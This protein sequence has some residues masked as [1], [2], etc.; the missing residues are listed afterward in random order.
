MLEAG[1]GAAK[2]HQWCRAQGGARG[3]LPDVTRVR[4]LQRAL[5][6]PV[7]WLCVDFI[8][9]TLK[10]GL[11]MCGDVAGELGRRALT[12]DSCEMACADGVSRHTAT[13]AKRS[14]SLLAVI[15]KRGGAARVRGAAGVRTTKCFLLSFF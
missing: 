12:A 13:A 14:G 3:G 10:N 4:D 2:Q 7:R 15:S 6:A 5:G 11:S 9:G 8:V 1:A